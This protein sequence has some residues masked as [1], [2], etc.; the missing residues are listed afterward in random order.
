MFGQGL[1]NGLPWREMKWP[2]DRLVFFK[3]R[4]IP[5]GKAN[6]R[7]LE[8]GAVVYL[9]QAVQRALAH[10]NLDELGH[11]AFRR[12]A[13]SWLGPCHVHSLRRWVIESS[14]GSP[15]HINP[16]AQPQECDR[17]TP[18]DLEIPDRSEGVPD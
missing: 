18:D 9:V 11:I 10:K 14:I 12:V 8:N 4:I 17:I 13:Q 1:L 2:D 16:G 7:P 5:I 3:E 6:Q 15:D